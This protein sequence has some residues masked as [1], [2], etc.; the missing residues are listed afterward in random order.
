M[1]DPQ[2]VDQLKLRREREAAYRQSRSIMDVVLAPLVGRVMSS[3]DYSTP[4]P[5]DEAD[6]IM[7]AGNDL[8]A[9]LD[10]LR[11]AGGDTEP[12]GD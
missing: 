7:A 10:D 1:S 11:A 6:R 12:S 3:P 4:V 8:M 2:H 9:K 5:Q